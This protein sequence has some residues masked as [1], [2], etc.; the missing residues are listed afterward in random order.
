MKKRDNSKS[1][2]Y[3]FNPPL[4]AQIRTTGAAWSGH[5]TQM[6][7]MQPSNITEVHVRSRNT[8]P[9]CAR[10]ELSVEWPALLNGKIPLQLIISGSVEVEHHWGF[11]VQLH[12]WKFKTRRLSVCPIAQDVSLLALSSPFVRSQGIQNVR[13]LENGVRA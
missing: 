9:L 13:A 12:S 7:W 2:A 4:A 6:N 3:S 1:R 11:V 8:K 10:I 5:V